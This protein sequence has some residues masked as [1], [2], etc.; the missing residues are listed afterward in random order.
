MV[1]S[2]QRK[3][4]GRSRAR[5]P[6][7]VA[8]ALLS[9]ALS[10]VPAALTVVLLNLLLGGAWRNPVVD[11]LLNTHLPWISTTGDWIKA[12]GEWAPDVLVW[13]AWALSIYQIW[14]E[15]IAFFVASAQRFDAMK[16]VFDPMFSPSII[17][18]VEG[19]ADTP[20]EAPEL[21]DGWRRQRN[22]FEALRSWI[23]TGSGDGSWGVWPSKPT[24]E[25]FPDWQPLSFALLTGA[26]GVGKSAL[27]FHFAKQISGSLRRSELVRH[28]RTVLLESLGTWF[29]TVLPWRRRCAGDPWD[30]G[31]LVP[32]DQAMVAALRQWEPR[33]PTLLLIDEPS[34]SAGECLKVLEARRE[35]FWHP[36]RVLLLDQAFPLAL[37]PYMSSAAVA[38]PAVKLFHGGALDLGELR[39]GVA[40]VRSM[41]NALCGQVGVGERPADETMARKLWASDDVNL[42][43]AIA[44][45]NPLQVALLLDQ[46]R[47][48]P[49]SLEKWIAKARCSDET[50]SAAALL[51]LE[52]QEVRHRLV[53]ERARD[54]VD[55]YLSTMQRL[56]PA[57]PGLL[58]PVIAAATVTGGLM[59]DDDTA[60]QVDARALAELFP[61][62]RLASDGLWI[63][64]VRPTIVARAFLADWI[65][66]VAAPRARASEL[67]RLVWRL[68][69]EGA[70][71]GMYDRVVLP[72]VLRAA[73]RESRETRSD[74]QLALPLAQ[75]DCI[76]V[77][78]DCAP[79][80]DAVSSMRS[81]DHR[82]QEQLL[83]WLRRRVEDGSRRPPEP[84]GAVLLSL[85]FVA[86]AL[87]LSATKDK[88]DVLAWGLAQLVRWM[89]ASG[90]VRLPRA[91]QRDLAD[92][93]DSF[94]LTALPFWGAD[95]PLGIAPWLEEMWTFSAEPGLRVCRR[96]V[97][98]TRRAEP[99]GHGTLDLTHVL[100]CAMRWRQA[101]ASASLRPGERGLEVAT[102]LASEVERL[103][104]AQPE[105]A[106]HVGLQVERAKAWRNASY[107][108]C[109]L[110]GER[111]LALSRSL[112][113]RVEGITSAQPEFAAHAGLQQVCVE[114]WRNACYAASELG[115]E[116]ALELS[117][118][119][120]ERVEGIATAHP[121]FAAYAGLQEERATSWRNACYAAS[122]LGGERALKLSQLL[123]ES[124]EGIATA[125][126]EFAAHAGL[127]AERAK[128]WRS[129]SYAAGQLGGERALELSRSLAERVE[130]ITTAQPEF[131]AHAGLQAERATVWRN[132]T[133]AASE[134]GG[135]RALELSRSLAERVEGITTAQPEFAAHAGLQ[136]ER[137]TAWRNASYA[138]SKLG[139]ERALELSQLLAE[140]VERIAT[141]R[142]EFAAHAGLQAER[143]KAWRNTSYAA[144]E[145]G[146]ERAL[147]L[148]R[149]LAGRVE[150]VA[151]AQPEFAAHA[152]LQT[153]RAKAWRNATYAASE[154]GGERALEL[155]RSLAERVEGI[156][157][158]QPEFA[159]HAGLQ[160][161]RAMSW[162]YASYAACRLVGERALEVSQSLAE[163]V[164]DIA[165]AQ[166]EF[167][168]HAGLQEERTKAWCNAAYAAC[169]L[170]G[171][172][173]LELSR[174]L[175]ER[176]EGI[177]SAQPE[178]AAHAGLQE[179]LATAWRCATYAASQLGGERALALSWSLAE[180]VEGV[181][182]AQ[183]ELATHAG[184]Q[185]EVKR[186]WTHVADRARADNQSALERQARL[187][188]SR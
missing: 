133:Y 166:P 10:M 116:R 135:E 148:S 62:R 19:P 131:A 99:A 56:D 160:A 41:W 152:G 145:L 126:P 141:A 136:E 34:S 118:S 47:R 97:R 139:G 3:N 100:L 130:G 6:T 50:F 92:A 121:E 1:E 159:A 12:Q 75:G 76:A 169:R 138:A 151:T 114:T 35:V 9:A 140:C 31:V 13:A 156:A 170:G 87:P 94:L 103:T 165:M 38:P 174:S 134:L 14:S 124:I 125:Q 95:W 161:E 68:E 132:A 115:G 128:A 55:T 173:A 70:S 84:L 177:T 54:L 64:P 109:L 7:W 11:T 52:H 112:A 60:A 43:I 146:G 154:L 113:E 187:R 59:L 107:A 32:Y 175:A 96:L 104:T 72:D 111:A 127:Q 181:V 71:R 157:M 8:R 106:A 186:A 110:G 153:E 105:F 149:S 178:F 129:T 51:V 40:A 120:A 24:Q 162:R 36:V 39:F 57:L 25:Y 29:R 79:A 2:Q 179:D 67:A 85:Y 183:P 158:A 23:E 137:A 90:A 168:A 27:A 30:V 17:P 15:R 123:A 22:A 81:L 58:M 78:C 172:H 144:G 167:A 119:M 42:A 180:R 101:T 108:A 48:T 188:A 21:H 45:G 176:V 53:A 18:W 74:Q 61:G 46:L 184:L 26:N 82:G 73:M 91:R 77:L 117:R 63:P 16:S 86:W 185:Q 102:R 66:R 33:R 89:P 163:R 98:E 28:R 88:G 65:G 20:Q 49:L 182:T 69:P 5:L 93:M 143:A 150:V 83:H 142:P 80:G 122:Q 155:S 147:E 171:E 164:E 44:Q 37:E 4:E